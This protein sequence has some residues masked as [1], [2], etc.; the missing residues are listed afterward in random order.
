[1]EHSGAA[2][3]VMEI[4]SHALQQGRAT[5]CQLDVAAFTNL[6][7]DHLDFHGDMESYLAAKLRIVDEL[8][9]D[10]PKPHRHLVVNVDDPHGEVLAARWPSV[11]RA[12]STVGSRADVAPLE[13][14]FDLDGIHA[15]L[16]TPSGTVAVESPLVGAFNL[17]NVAVAVAVACALGIDPGAME[18]GLRAARRIPG[19]LEPVT[20]TRVDETR[21]GEPRVLVDY[22]HTPDALARV[23]EALR[24]V[25][26][27][28]LWVVFGCGGDRDRGKR[29]TMGQAACRGADR[30]VV[31]SDNP[32]SEDP[33]AIIDQILA[34]VRAEGGD[35][36][37]EPDR[38]LAIDTAIALAG[39]DDLVL[40]A[41]KGHERV[42]IVGAREVPFADQDIARD[43]LRRRAE[44]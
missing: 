42:Q 6:T 34:G 8:L 28:Q 32:R 12:S 4:S 5:A 35:C 39:P 21:H 17:S 40:I 30:V 16:T 25:V 37:V 36:V 29:H 9:A 22:A 38:K 7:R 26:P 27:G 2:A 11:L 44:S 24:A 33:R 43:A 14:R 15:V 18:G 41:G 19:R 31:T 1:M 23:L 20:W 13:A 10:S 3:V